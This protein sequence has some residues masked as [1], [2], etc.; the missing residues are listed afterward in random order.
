MTT[1]KPQFGDVDAWGLTHPGKVRDTNQDHFLA[2]ALTSGVQVEETS[3]DLELDSVTFRERTASFAVVA[4]GVGSSG[5]GEHAARV[6]VEALAREVSRSFYR[7]EMAEATDPDVFSR[8]LQDAALTCH[9][10]LV[11][12]A[13]RE[14]GEGS[15][16]TTVTLFLGL[17]PHAY[18]LQVGDS[19]CYIYRGGELTQITRDQTWAQDLIDQGTLSQTRAQATRW[20]NVL[21]SSIG[22][23]ESTPVV[24][25]IER[26]WGDVILLCSDGLTKHVSDERIEERIAG[27]QSSRQL[28]EDLLDDALEAGGTD[29]VTII[30]GRTL[31]PTT[32]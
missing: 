3:L 31:P 32:A 17:W 10:S 20:A 24:T 6:A 13:A 25:R 1:G 8:M 5:G 18:L 9:E 26:S 19:R 21:S 23:Q 4:D 12:R 2:G 28:A 29:N 22:G 16:A 15:F 14:P 30:V 11:R 7:A 27:M